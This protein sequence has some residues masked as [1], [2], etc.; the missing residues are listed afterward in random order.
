MQRFKNTVFNFILLILL[1]LPAGCEE[2]FSKITTDKIDD[3][4]KGVT[5]R[6]ISSPQLNDG[7]VGENYIALAST[8]TEIFAAWFEDSMYLKVKLFNNDM[9]TPT[10]NEETS[11]LTYTMPTNGVHLAPWNDEMCIAYGDNG[12]IIAMKFDTA[13]RQ[14]VSLVDTA[15]GVGSISTA[16]NPVLAV[17]QNNLYVLFKETSAP[18]YLRMYR[19]DGGGQWTE[20]ADTANPVNGVNDNSN[21][22]TNGPSVAVTEN[23]M[24]IAFSEYTSNN[25]LKIR[26]YNGLELE[27]P[28]INNGNFNYW[29]INDTDSNPS[30]TAIG[31]DIYVGWIQS[32][33]SYINYR[34]P[35]FKRNTDGDWYSIDN[36]YNGEIQGIREIGDTTNGNLLNLQLINVNKRLCALSVDETYFSTGNPGVVVKIYDGEREGWHEWLWG[37]IIDRPDEYTETWQFASYYTSTGWIDNAR[38]IAFD[39]KLFVV[40]RDNS[41]L[42]AIVGE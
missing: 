3:G 32:D 4:I 27:P 12:K 18:S 30:I 9:E 41:T 33:G 25:K 6:T 1:F 39:E 10:W 8:S 29:D 31:D 24:Y 34:F 5:W 36:S 7:M 35:V 42:Y 14:W 38:G 21:D 40:Y 23:R 20:I 37:G 16:T 13:T 19:F 11:G 2:M 22:V 17:F 26:P 15:L 28:D